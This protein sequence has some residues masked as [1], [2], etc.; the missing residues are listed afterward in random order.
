[1]MYSTLLW[2]RRRTDIGATVIL[3]SGCQ[4][5]QTSADG[6][7]NGLFTEKLLQ[8]W[9]DGNFT[10]TLPQFHKG[11]LTLMPSNQTPNY[12]EVGT[13]DETFTN[14]RP[15]RIVEAAQPQPGGVSPEPAES[16]APSITGPDA[17]DRGSDDPPSFDVDRGSNSYYMVEVTSD[18]ELFGRRAD[19]SAENFYG[20]YDDPEV[21]APYTSST[22]TLP[23]SAWEVLKANDKLFYRVVSTSSETDWKNT[24][25]STW[26]GDAVT[27]APFITIEEQRA[28]QAARSR[29]AEVDLQY[30]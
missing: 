1:R 24:M 19:R 6:D 20:S 12:L 18:P 26:D 15:L 9:D 23:Q 17:Y 25:F 10:G 27:S 8:I 28:A 14:S 30:Q 16:Q 4:D 3:I 22:Y 21:L 2:S 5:N 7:T 13:H 11:I 29:E